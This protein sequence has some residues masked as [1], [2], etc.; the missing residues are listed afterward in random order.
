M[1]EIRHGE[2]FEIADLAGLT[3]S[4]ARAKFQDEFGIPDK[5]VAKLNGTKVK[6]S[7]EADTV[8]NDDD[9]L[10]FAVV[11][12][13]VPYLVGAVLLALGITGGVFAAGFINATVVL[14]PSGTLTYNF[15]EVTAN[16]TAAS[17]LTWN[18]WGYYKG[19]INSSDNP[20]FT[21]DTA[22]SNYTGDFVVS[23]TLGNAGD[24]AKCYRVLGLKLGLKNSAGTLV[25]IN[26]DNITS[27][28]TDWVMLTLDNGS[29]SMFPKGA[30]D[31]YTVCVLKGFYI[32][33]ARPFAGWGSADPSPLMFCEVAQR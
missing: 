32:T 28:S 10:A 21:V 9:T 30:V 29:V 1:V 24:L 16:Q 23:V 14:N 15:A 26:E 19:S 17:A 4:E 27:A 8:I 6:R 25:D 22:T 33:H 12:S 11:R 20:I 7:V 2:H 13:R 3:I 5:A 31:T 18:A